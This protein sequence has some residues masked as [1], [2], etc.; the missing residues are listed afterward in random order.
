VI[1]LVL[2]VKTDRGEWHFDWVKLHLPIFGA[3][4]QKVA[5]S[6]F[7][8][9]FATLIK[10]GVPILGAL[11]IVSATSG[12]RILADA[13]DTARESVRQGESLGE[14]LARFKVFPPMVTRMISIG[15]KSGALESLLEKISEFY[16]QQVKATIASLTSLIEPIMLGTMGFIVGT[17]VLAILMPIIELQKK[18]SGG[19]G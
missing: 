5:I 11:E 1:A 2:Y 9:T 16:D 14:P 18:L 10:S 15:E 8:R 7:A 19:G 13:V 6:R 12:N 4:F 17:I 3:L